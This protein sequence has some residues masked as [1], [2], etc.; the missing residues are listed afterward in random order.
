[1]RKL[2]FLSAMVPESKEEKK[3]GQWLGFSQVTGILISV[4][5]YCTKIK[6]EGEKNKGVI[7]SVRRGFWEVSGGIPCLP[8]S[9]WTQQWAAGTGSPRF[10]PSK[11]LHSARDDTVF[12]HLLM[13]KGCEGPKINPSYHHGKMI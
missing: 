2:N 13:C 5:E 11:T 8:A 1:M 10:T 9:G 3:W 4:S 6:R 7:Q 12:L